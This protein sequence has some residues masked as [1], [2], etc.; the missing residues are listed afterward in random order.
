LIVVTHQRKADGIVG[1]LVDGNRRA[2]LTTDP[3]LREITYVSPGYLLF[4]RIVRNAGL[5]GL[6]FD[7]GPLDLAKATLVQAGSEGYDVSDEGT[8]LVKLELRRK[9]SLVWVDRGGAMSVLPGS[10]A[11]LSQ[12]ALSPDGRRAAFIEGEWTEGNLVVRDLATG[13]DTRQTFNKPDDNQGFAP[14]TLSPAWFPDSHRILYVTGGVEATALVARNADSAGEARQ[15]EKGGVFGIVSP[16]GRNLIFVVDDRGHGRLHLASLSADG[17]AGSGRPMF[18]R[19]ADPDIMDVA[20]SPNGHVLAYEASQP[21]RT[22]SV[23]LTEFPTGASRWLVAENGKHP[24]FSP[25]G[26]QLYYVKSGVDARGEPKAFFMSAP[27]TVDPP[28]KIGVAAELFQQNDTAGPHINSFEV[29]PDG[30]RFL[31]TKPIV[32]P[33]DENRLVLVQNWTAAMKR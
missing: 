27:L 24:R 9:L 22:S 8:L 3:T 28:V 16:D 26:R 29:S 12:P 4:R 14:L 7:G 1:E 5:W 6:P 33:G 17:T 32:S 11:V 31:M 2:V 30:K 20:L 21:N 23:F 13:V 10:A 19:D 25:D 15:I 18:H